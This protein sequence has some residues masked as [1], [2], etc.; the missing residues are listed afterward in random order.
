[1]RLWGWWRRSEPSAGESPD[2]GGGASGVRDELLSAYLDGE[3][4]EA[5]AAGIED[6]LAADPALATELD[7]L[8][9]L[10]EAL[11]EL[12]ELRAPRPFTL[13]APPLA[14]RGGLSRFEIASRMGAVAAAVA[15]AVVLSGD[16][17]G[18]GDD[19]TSS[20]STTQAEGGFVTAEAERPEPAAGDAGASDAGSDDAAA[21]PASTATPQPQEAAT[22][23]GAAAAA[24]EAT[25]ARL[26]PA[27]DDAPAT[28][29]RDSALQADTT[30]DAVVGGAEGAAPQA[31]PDSSPAAAT[32]PV[33]S[34]AAGGGATEEA[35][36]GADDEAPADSAGDGAGEAAS[37]AVAEQP[38]QTNDDAD[39]APPEAAT[40]VATEQ[41][42]PPA[43]PA[44][45]E[46]AG[47]ADEA[48]TSIEGER[49]NSDGSDGVLQIIELGLLLA[50]LGFVGVALVQRFARRGS[51]SG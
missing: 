42:A 1:M 25:A 22:N 24:P 44:T 36:A 43:V 6:G 39:A 50:A 4:D 7:E 37:P 45:P 10:R 33:E 30:A 23:D 17:A 34:L 28:E 15:F 38:S 2:E 26:A 11:S 18:L 40:P 5:Q 29:G 16:I 8:R 3:L 27:D 14:A 19:G 31:A 51:E 49:S 35:P 9:V 12:G 20:R 46:G 21:A 32:A 41:A 47:T 13:E 48:R